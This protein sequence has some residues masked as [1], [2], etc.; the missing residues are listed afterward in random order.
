MSLVVTGRNLAAGWWLAEAHPF[1]DLVTQ[2]MQ[3]NATVKENGVVELL[4]VEPRTK[5][6]L[7]KSTEVVDLQPS[8]HVAAC[9]SGP[10]D[11][12][13]DLVDDVLHRRGAV[14]PHE[15]DRLLPA[16]AVVVHA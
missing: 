16:P 10:C 14:G 15:V 7:G 4:Y 8:D 1:R 3:R 9:L 12:A 11:V 13:V 2:H 5:L 6:V